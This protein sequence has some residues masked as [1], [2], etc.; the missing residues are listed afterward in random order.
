MPDLRSASTYRPLLTAIL[1]GLISFQPTLQAASSLP[2]GGTFAAGSGQIKSSGNILNINQSS[3]RAIIDWS[4]FSIAP[5]ASVNFNNGAGATLNRVTGSAASTILGQLLATGNIYLINP[6]GILIGH[7][8]AIH[9]GGDFLAS[10]LNLSNSVFLN[11]GALLFTGSSKAAVVNLGDL[12]SSGG[13]IYL[14]GHSVQNGGSITAANGTTGLAAGSQVLITDSATGQ[15]VAVQAPGGDVTNSGFISAAQVELKSNGGNIYALAG[16]NGGQITATGTATQDGHVWLIATNGTTNVQSAISAANADGTGGAIETSGAHVTTSGAHITTGKNGNWLLDPDNL[17]IDSTLAGTIETTLNGGTNVTEQTGD[18][19]SGNGDIFVASNIAWT[20]AANL[21]L[22]AYRD[23]NINSAVTISN[24][25]AGN[26]TLRADNAANGIGAVNINGL[27]DFS[28]S[29]GN[30]AIFYNPSGSAT[31]KYTTPVSYSIGASGT[32]VLTNSAWT[33]PTDYSVSSQATAY[34]LV[35]NTT[36]L[37]N[38]YTNLA[39][40]FALGTNID[41]TSIGNFTPIGNSSNFTGIFDGQNNTI[42][43]LTVNDTVDSYAGM[44]GS[45]T[46][47]IRNLTL[48]NESVTATSRSVGGLV[49]VSTGVIANAATGGAISMSGSNSSYVGGLLGQNSGTLVNSNSSASVTVSNSNIQTYEGGLAGFN[50]RSIANSYA[51]GAVTANTPSGSSVNFLPYI[52]G[53]V[54]VNAGPVTSS[55]ATGNVIAGSTASTWINMAAGG[56]IGWSNSAGTITDTYATGSVTSG[57]NIRAG[58]LL[59]YNAGA[60]VNTSLA[61]GSVSATTTN[62]AG[63]LLGYSSG[64]VT[65]S[66]WDTSTT[67]QSGASGNS[68]SVS[69][70]TGQPTA[71]LQS[72]TLPSGFSSSNWYGLAGIYPYLSWQGPPVTISGTAYNAAGSALASTSVG[73][74]ASG[75]LHNTLTTNASGFFSIAEPGYLLSAGS[76]ILAYLTNNPASGT[77]SDGLGS[78]NFTGMDIHAGTLTLLNGTSSNL[79]GL[80]AALLSAVGSNFNEF[81]RVFDGAFQVSSGN[82]TI[83]S[84]KEPSFTID[85]SIG[86]FIPAPEFVPGSPV[87]RSAHTAVGAG[88]ILITSASDLI[89]DPDQTIVTSANKDI[90]LVSGG[91]FTNNAGANVF[92]VAGDG[93]WFVYS[94]NPANDTT[95]GLA[96]D[97]LQ[98]NATYGVT[99]PG[100][101]TGNGLLYTLAPTISATLIGATSKTYDG[102]TAAT[103]TSANFTS[104]GSIQGDTVTL[105]TPSS[106]TYADPNVNTGIGV[107]ASGLSLVSAVNGSI[108]VYGY[109]LASTTAAGNIG[110][111]NP[112]TLTYTANSATQT[113]GSSNGTYTGSVTGFVNQETL[114]TAT[115][116]TLAFTSPA[117]PTSVVGN[118]AIN[119]SGLTAGNYTFVQ[120]ASNASA[121]TITSANAPPP[122]PGNPTVINVTI[123]NV[124]RLGDQPNPV[125]TYTGPTLSGLT[126]QTTATTTST[127]GTYLITATGTAPDGYT[128]NIIPGTLTI[129]DDTPH[130]APSQVTT[131]VSLPVLLPTPLNGASDFLEPINALGQFHIAVAT[132]TSGF[133]SSVTVPSSPDSPFSQFSFFGGSDDRKTT[134]FAGAKP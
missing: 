60:T 106:G 123:N 104:T 49:G 54:G 121:L 99:S 41:A 4:T 42:Y 43:N 110:T 14:I 94:Q 96:E 103:L 125:F 93:R 40:K 83:T 92:T 65:S 87:S 3:L 8:A 10:T 101:S 17:T 107:S 124:T 89:I 44:F 57:T 37:Q 23:L 72:G 11:N 85:Q 90:T 64:T 6:Q 134:Y 88:N 132:T 45:S 53:L 122:P 62:F 80:T 133:G 35:N 114:G 38:V 63:G 97:F 78:Q 95:G 116:G 21:T 26:L 119:G 15:R 67:G 76:G 30:V 7:G 52:G 32:Q 1:I 28:G 100:Q 130:T 16:N 118:Y 12:A 24:T 48:N 66:Y 55:F 75:A 79:S 61:T 31:T 2:T 108:P 127:A 102:T 39:G 51:T 91:V 36:D 71:T 22:S 18:S 46:G 115:T 112:A 27:V 86:Y 84:T 25:G 47:I 33:A 129:I 29:T 117:T 109:Q 120:A 111:I 56:L 98:Y 77:F 105:S 9:T 68:A 113:Y 70:A 34:M 59:G 82:L 81:F 128:L 20:T 58:G 19:N 74:Y 13:S 5:G 73:I 50:A 131:N 69:G 126:F